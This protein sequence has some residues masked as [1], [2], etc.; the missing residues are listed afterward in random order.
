MRISQNIKGLLVIIAGMAVTGCTVVVRDSG[1][2]DHAPA[3]GYSSQVD[4][5]D[6]YYYYPSARVYFHIYTGYYYYLRG[7][8]W[9]RSR[10]L[11][12]YIR[13][14]RHDRYR[15]QIKDRYPYRRDH[16]YR[17]KYRPRPYLKRDERDDA[18]ERE[19]NS[20]RYKEYRR[21]GDDRSDDRYRDR[22]Q[23]RYERNQDPR[24]ELFL[25]K[26]RPEESNN[27]PRR[28]LLLRK[29]RPE[30]G[31]QPEY[32]RPDRRDERSRDQDRR[33]DEKRKHNGKKREDK[34]DEK[35][36]S[37]DRDSDNR[38]DSRKK[39]PRSVLFR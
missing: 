21:R 34:S 24:R 36:D 19:Q 7:N 13:L 1:P 12:G 30:A 5:Y 8:H 11:P 26:K 17:R 4:Y 31:D 23:D 15:L 39:D 29:K 6:D 3:V 9:V 18:R 28:E 25:P 22:M 2:P 14:H 32:R 20:R 33:R 10:V 16:E 38:N 27:D 37:D 35:S